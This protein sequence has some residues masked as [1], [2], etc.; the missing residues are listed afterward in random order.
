MHGPHAG[1]RV[2]EFASA[3]ATARRAGEANGLAVARRVAAADPSAVAVWAETVAVLA[4]VLAAIVVTIAPTTIVVGGGLAC[5]GSL[6][7]EPLE[8]ELARRLGGLRAPSLLA[9]HHGDVAAAVGASYLAA[10]LAARLREDASAAIAP[11]ARGT[12]EQS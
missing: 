9:A 7:L 5:A 4:D 12:G 2:E 10:D 8:V 11:N 6:L 3:T 1:L